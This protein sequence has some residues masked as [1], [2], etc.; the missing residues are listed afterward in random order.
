MKPPMKSRGAVKRGR[1]IDTVSV[2]AN[3]WIEL[4]M[5]TIMLAAAKKTTVTTGSP[6]ANMW[7]AQTPKPMNA[8]SSSA[9]ATSGNAS[10]LRPENVGMIEVAIPKAGRT[11]M[12]TSGWPKNQNR[13]CQRIGEP[14]LATSKKC[15]PALR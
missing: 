1:P 14:P 6:T 12:Y 7:C 4:G 10:I 5:T 15:K 13:C 9:S 8:T 2:Q 3:T 11:M